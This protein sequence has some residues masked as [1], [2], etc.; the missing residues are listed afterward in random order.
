MLTRKNIVLAG[1]FLVLMGLS[2]CTGNPNPYPKGATPIPT[3]S[4]VMADDMIEETAV[5]DPLIIEY[6]SAS[7]AAEGG[8]ALYVEH[9]AECHAEDGT[10]SVPNAHD[11]TDTA[12]R[13][14]KTP[15]E[16]FQ[17]T[18]SGH[19]ADVPDF[20]TVLSADERW[21]VVYYVWRFAAPT[22]SLIVGQELYA[23]H[24]A[25]CHG[26]AGTSELVNV[27]DLADHQLMSN[28]SGDTFFTAMTQGS[29]DMPSWQARLSQEERWA[30]VN[31]MRTFTY[32]PII[33]PPV[34]EG[35]D[36]TEGTTEEPAFVVEEVAEDEKPAC[37]AAYLEQS[38]PFAWDD[39]DAIAAGLLLYEDN[40]VRCHADD[41]AGADGLSYVPT[42]LT[43]ADVQTYLHENGG[44]YLCRIAEGLNDMPAMKRKMDQ[45]QMWRVLTYVGT[46][47][48]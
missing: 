15:A 32:N 16:F 47:G 33:P 29:D 28:Q 44:E 5:A 1:L 2:A 23:E 31:F 38:N 40:C 22:A 35:E 24:C 17:A 42:N 30:V 18:T 7:P 4:P 19:T 12:Y 36:G 45:E 46:L 14:G 26:A 9:C 21:D 8:E 43:D 34:V 13:H 41:G 10:G 20:S 48:P 27:A 39:A 3:L 6:P 11:F 25:E 37:D